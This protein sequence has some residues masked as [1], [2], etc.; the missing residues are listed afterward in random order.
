MLRIFVRGGA[1][2]HR[3]TWDNETIG[4]FIE[5]KTEKLQVLHLTSP[6]LLS[7]KST[8]RCMFYYSTKDR[9]Q[10]GVSLLVIS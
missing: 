8:I 2:S 1:P 6:C 4:T 5:H 3:I 10:V 7:D 9:K